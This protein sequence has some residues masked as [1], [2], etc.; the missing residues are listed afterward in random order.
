MENIEHLVEREKKP[1]FKIILVFIGLIVLIDFTLIIMNQFTEKIPYITT[2]ATIVL[3]LVSCTFIL[4]KYFSKYL[5]DF[6][7]ENL[8]FYRLIGKRDFHML[9]INR[10][11]LI[12]IKPIDQVDKDEKYPYKFIFPENEEQ[13]YMGEFKGENRERVKFLFT[14][15]DEILKEIGNKVKR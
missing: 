10:K 3:V 1:V 9:T 15:N 7:E 4:M 5:Y 6:D 2:F 11:D 14:P 12:Y 13:I 8:V